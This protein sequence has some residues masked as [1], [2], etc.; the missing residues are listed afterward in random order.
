M[1]IED[2]SHKIIVKT[3][4]LLEEKY[5]YK[6]PDVHKHEIETLVMSNIDALIAGKDDASAKKK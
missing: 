3:L 1:R 6:I 5:H 4:S 2:L